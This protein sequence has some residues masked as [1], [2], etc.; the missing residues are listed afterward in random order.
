MPGFN[1]E[2]YEPVSARIER[3]WKDHPGGRIV[4]RSEP[5]GSGEFV[6]W[7]GVY[8]EAEDA[9]MA[10]GWA[11]E[12]AGEGNVNRTSALEN[13]ETSAIGRALANAG[14][15]TSRQRA[16]REEM[17]KATETISE[18][19]GVALV[20]LLQR[21]GEY[22]PRWVELG[23]PN[24]RN[25][26]ALPRQQFGQ[27]HQIL[28]DALRARGEVEGGGGQPAPAD[29]GAD[30]DAANPSLALRAEGSHPLPP[31]WRAL[32]YRDLVKLAAEHGIKASGSAEAITD[33]LSDYEASLVD[34]P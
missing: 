21:L 15:S 27:A 5:A 34:A 3:F 31:D 4:T 2:D 8:R 33:R 26:A 30:E 23:L 12:V 11:R 19:E 10:T 29:S 16:S 1:L 20:D 13:C 6:F 32:P 22:P 28:T 18:T 14:Y 24:S 25:I 7:A 17:V 9:P